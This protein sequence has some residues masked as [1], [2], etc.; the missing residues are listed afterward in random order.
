M[1]KVLA[2]LFAVC[3]SLALAPSISAQTRDGTNYRSNA[4]CDDVLIDGKWY[5]TFGEGRCPVGSRRPARRS[6]DPN[7]Q[8][9]Q[10]MTAQVA[11]LQS[12]QQSLVTAGAAI[13]ARM[14]ASANALIEAYEFNVLGSDTGEPR[15]VTRTRLFPEIGAVSMARL[16]EAILISATGFDGDC[17]VPNFSVT[18][19]DFTTEH[20]VVEGAVACKIKEND[21]AFTPLYVN[22]TNR[23]DRNNAM[24]MPWDLVRRRDG[25]VSLCLRSLGFNTACTPAR[26]AASV[27][28]VR[29]FITE[30]GNKV[31]K[32]TLNSLEG[33]HLSFTA[34]G[35]AND[36]I[37]I[38][39]DTSS[40]FVIEGHEFEVMGRAEDALV[41]RRLS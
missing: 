30:R 31:P 36:V 22:S 18:H 1:K 32:A 38:D 4:V 16:G 6:S 39:A 11:A 10:S 17:I 40:R 5:S 34:L 23:L 3:G 12:A 35:A 37:T 2:C 7:Q 19:L 9:L 8:A 33:S 27:S 25:S 28:S 41:Y 15:Y 20:A 14:M 26:D 13:G 21:R 24:M 29:A